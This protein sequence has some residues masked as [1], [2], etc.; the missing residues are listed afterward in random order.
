M[1]RI[2]RDIKLTE[3]YIKNQNRSIELDQLMIQHMTTI[4]SLQ[5]KFNIA[6]GEYLKTQ[7]KIKA[8]E[9]LRQSFA[10]RGI[11][12]SKA[13]EEKLAKIE[14]QL[15]KVQAVNEDNLKTLD[16]QVRSI[17]RQNE[18]WKKT[19]DY[20]GGKIQSGLRGVWRYTVDTDKSLKSITKSMG[21]FG[22]RSE[23]VRTNIT[24]SSEAAARLGVS[25]EDL[26]KMQ[27][28]YSNELGTQVILTGKNLKN[29]SAIAQGTILGSENTGK[30][31]ADFA[32][33]GG[34]ADDFR[35]TIEGVVETSERMALNTGKVL[36][37]L[38]H[39]FKAIQ[40]YNFKQG[41]HGIADMAMYA[42]K[43]K[44]DIQDALNSTEKARTLEGAI[45]MM[46][47]LQVL[48]GEFAKSDPFEMLFLAR[49]DPEKYAKKLNDMTK[50]MANLVKTASGFELNITGLDRDRLKAFAEATGQDYGKV[51]EQAMARGKFDSIRGQ[52]IG[53]GLSDK[54]QEVI[55]S[56][57]Q[58]NKGTGKFMYGAKQLS[59]LTRT[60]IEAMKAQSKTLEQR[61][62]ETQDFD[63]AFQSTIMELKASLLPILNRVNDA[64]KWL[65]S[66]KDSWMG[67]AKMFFKG[68]LLIGAVMAT[69]KAIK[70]A[71]SLVGGIGGKIGGLLSGGAGAGSA[72][73]PGAGGVAGGLI[74]GGAAK[75]IAAFGAAAAGAGAGIGLAAAGMSLLANAVKNLSPEQISKLN[76]LFITLGVTMGGFAIA[77]GVVAAI[78]APAALPILALGAAIFLV[79]AGIGAAAAGL[80]YFA[81][82][83]ATVMTTSKGVDGGNLLKIGG[84]IG[85]I[86]LGLTTMGNPLAM[87]GLLN[88]S[89]TLAMLSN[90]SGI[91]ATASAV[92]S[93]IGNIKGS[94]NELEELRAM[95]DSIAGI[96][97]N[98]DSV[99]NK[100][101]NLLDN[102][103]KVEFT[104]KELALS[105]NIDAYLDKEKISRS[106]N[107][108]ERIK[109][110]FIDEKIGRGAGTTMK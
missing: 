11:K 31:A 108:S 95:L 66:G 61:A 48:G 75:S 25:V 79:G 70:F 62:T 100:L 12:L 99:I 73:T 19:S 94:K 81:D 71:S 82:G 51:I 44:V 45:D 13:Q 36:N 9:E 87:L 107:I 6:T 15:R 38:N 4:N 17:Q 91:G 41:V 14:K 57:V 34:S 86:G 101:T 77:I 24:S 10:Q 49:N 80:G 1:A 67:T 16:K 68:A 102:P 20:I 2:Q 42:T 39:N 35:Q 84:G 92:N 74:G 26:A 18:A 53:L 60:D 64:I 50:G 28:E 7:T 93:L 27:G 37:N 52:L 105:V 69:F 55:E 23:T 54:D 85:A 76:N 58:L 90:A 33:I 97:V 46:S 59:N 88:L 89:G 56:M 8:Y 65:N 32:A 22:Q 29:L 40:K 43:F 21:T 109:A 3:E 83:I 104:E 5:Q 72:A 110:K 63:K 78:A 106:M 47:N 96:D 30:M 98:K 103:L